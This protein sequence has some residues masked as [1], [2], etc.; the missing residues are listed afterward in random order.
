MSVEVAA[1][2]AAGALEEIEIHG[3]R[4]Q[5]ERPSYR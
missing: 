2:E 3:E 4:S 5:L 1:K